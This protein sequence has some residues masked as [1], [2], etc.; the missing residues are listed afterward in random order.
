MS[1]TNHFPPH[2]GASLE[3]ATDLWVQM[4]GGTFFRRGGRVIFELAK[5][6]FP[7]DVMVEMLTVTGST[8]RKWLKTGHMWMLSN[9]FIGYYF[10]LVLLPKLDYKHQVRLANILDE[11]HHYPRTRYW[12]LSEMIR[13]AMIEKGLTQAQLRAKVGAF[14][15][16]FYK[17]LRGHV[18][19]NVKYARRLGEV[20][21]IPDFDVMCYLAIWSYKLWS[22]PFKKKQRRGLRSSVRSTKSKWKRKPKGSRPRSLHLSFKDTSIF[23]FARRKRKKR[24]GNPTCDDN[25]GSLH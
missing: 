21:G 22:P 4:G 10:G 11:V 14:R 20:L 25:K 23:S 9:R 7:E 6:N 13:F 15:K 1:L 5:K 12:Y 8:T 17:W 18:A 24:N 3:R 16:R 2:F 19:P